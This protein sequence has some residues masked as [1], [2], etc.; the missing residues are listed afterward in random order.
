MPIMDFRFALIP[1][2]AIPLGL[3]S[4]LLAKRAWRGWKQASA[5]RNWPQTP[6]RVVES[7]IRETAVRARRQTSA[8]STRQATRYAPH[9]VYAYT[10]HGASYQ[11]ERLRFGPVTLS[12]EAGDAGRAASRY[13]LG[14]EVTVYYD[15]ANPAESALDLRPGWGIWIEG[16]LALFLLLVNIAVIA[17]LL[18]SPAS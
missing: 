10:V 17:L 3:V 9:I 13:P 8:A 15:P 5:A 6:G 12:S 4:L 1:A 16:L 18:G 2:I 11:G 14:S 7:G